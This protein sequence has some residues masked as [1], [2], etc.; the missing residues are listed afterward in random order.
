MSE[1]LHLFSVLQMLADRDSVWVCIDA[2]SVLR[3]RALMPMAMTS[4]T[5]LSAGINV[6]THSILFQ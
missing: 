5:K 2:Y 4:L 3:C 1:I 6:T